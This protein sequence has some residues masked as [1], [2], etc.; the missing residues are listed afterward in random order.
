MCQGA[1]RG[2]LGMSLVKRLL[3]RSVWWPSVNTDDEKSVSNSETWIIISNRPIIREPHK[4]RVLFSTIDLANSFFHVMLEKGSRHILIFI[5]KKHSTDTSAC[6]S[7]SAR[8]ETLTKSCESSGYSF[9]TKADKSEI[10]PFKR[11]W[12]N[13]RSFSMTYLI[14]AS[15]IH[16][17]EWCLLNSTT[18]SWMGFKTSERSKESEKDNYPDICYPLSVTEIYTFRGPPKNSQIFYNHQLA[19]KFCSNKDVSS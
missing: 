11:H 9:F 16:R 13:E 7:V 10:S 14:V 4:G 5:Q 12:F 2:H 15:A 18:A 17:L 3:R 19:F 8:F 6:H 1:H